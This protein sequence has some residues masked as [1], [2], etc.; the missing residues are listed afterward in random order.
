MLRHKALFLWDEREGAR[1]AALTKSEFYLGFA[2]IDSPALLTDLEAL[3]TIKMS[4]Q[5]LLSP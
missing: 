5:A 2:V 4:R 1:D 3:V